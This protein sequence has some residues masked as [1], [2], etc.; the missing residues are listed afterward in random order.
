M[1]SVFYTSQAGVR[2]RHHHAIHVQLT[3]QYPNRVQLVT[4]MRSDAQGAVISQTLTHLLPRVALQ[5]E[6]FHDDWPVIGLINVLDA[7]LCQK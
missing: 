7:V 1:P 6:D 4:W 2:F 5:P 3:M